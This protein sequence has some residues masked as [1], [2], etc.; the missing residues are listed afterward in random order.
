MKILGQPLGQVT[1]A[2]GWAVEVSFQQAHNVKFHGTEDRG[3]APGTVTH[4]LV[5]SKVNRPNSCGKYAIWSVMR[6]DGRGWHVSDKR[7]DT[8][9]TDQSH[10]QGSQGAHSTTRTSSRC[11]CDSSTHP[12]TARMPQTPRQDRCLNAQ[13]GARVLPHNIGT[14]QKG[15]SCRKH[16]QEGQKRSSEPCNA[17]STQ[18]MMC[19]GAVEQGHS[20]GRQ[21]QSDA[22]TTCKAQPMI[23]YQY[24]I[25]TQGMQG[26]SQHTGSSVRI[27]HRE[28]HTH[29]HG[30]HDPHAMRHSLW[31]SDRIT[32]PGEC[33]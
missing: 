27:P 31:T 33:N 7:H 25:Y 10:Q 16:T 26:N 5:E 9:R 1:I 20:H 24:D 3:H 29:S 6:R 32:C 12:F 15:I 14:W 19:K 22:Q 28:S 13:Q 21:G 17:H 23:I 8:R 2:K 30:T 18:R 11:M 4:Q